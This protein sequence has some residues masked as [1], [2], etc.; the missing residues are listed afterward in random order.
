[1]L[2]NKYYEK[3]KEY[4]KY[5]F[6]FLIFIS[7]LMVSFHI[8]TDYSIYKPGGS[9][10]I[11]ERIEESNDTTKSIGSFNMAYV[12][13][14]RGKLP[15]YLFAHIMPSWELV[16]NE[17]ITYND[18]ETIND[19][20][21]R[22]K[23]YYDE[24]IS[25]AIYVAYEKSNT[26]YKLVNTKSFITYIDEASTGDFIIGD[27]ILSYDNNKFINIE[28]LK[29]YINTKLVGDEIT[30][31][32]KRNDKKIST[33][34]KIFMKDN[35]LF[36]GLSAITLNY[37]ESDNNIKI[38]EKGSESGP[39]GGLI[40]SLAIYDALLD[41]DITKG[42]KIV[43]TGAIEL[44]GT[45]GEIGGVKY[46]LAGAVKDKADI[47]IVPTKNYK[48]ATEYAKK[49]KYDIIIKEVSSFD[50]AINIL[51]DLEEKK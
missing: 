43:G 28:T 23:L 11:T 7:L 16:K 27:E 22:D 2:T 48:E 50:D 18:N 40:L 34:T 3:T 39:S 17:E 29:E 47:F 9:I 49:K 46:K 30:F 5:N 15:F 31:N 25:N 13:M 45:V 12:G 37:I 10:D 20:I 33:S 14:V 32:L 35:N 8:E 21:R 4:I 51:N 41:K 19:A 6:G 36:I 38:T 44:D 42:N 24:S 1:M 26:P